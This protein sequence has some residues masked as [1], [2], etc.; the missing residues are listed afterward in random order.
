[1]RSASKESLSVPS[2]LA[3][4]K[5]AVGPEV[6]GQGKRTLE[7]FVLCVPLIPEQHRFEPRGASFCGSF[8]CRTEC[9]CS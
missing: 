8:T 7:A 6:P 2:P 5:S 4:A 3:A 1:M 9:V